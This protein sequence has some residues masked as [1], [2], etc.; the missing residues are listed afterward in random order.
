MK[1]PTPV[2]DYRKLRLSNLMSDQFRH[3]LL[4]LYWPVYGLSFLFVERFF[5]VE[6]YHPMHCFLD[7][8]IPFQELFLIPYLLWFVF[9]VGMIAYTLFYDIDAFKK[10]MHFII[11]TYSVTIFIYLVYPTCQN[12][13]P[14]EF[15]RD[16]I[17]TRIMSMYYAFDTN[18]NV[19]PSLHVTGS[20]AVMYAAWHCKK[21][22]HPAWKISFTVMA[23]LISISTVFVKQHSAVDVIAAVILCA[24]AYPLCF[25]TSRSKSPAAVNANPD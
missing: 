13:R 12:L 9:L 7:D 23:L 2:V 8:L 11:L 21:L 25:R 14:T 6:Y 3:L 19:C 1:L 18:T 10:M 20:F 24:V 17:L 15:E 16:N 5:H 22:Q 4:L